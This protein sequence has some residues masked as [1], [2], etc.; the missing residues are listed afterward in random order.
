MLGSSLAHWGVDG[1]LLGE[2]L[3]S[4]TLNLATSA[5]PLIGSYYFLKEQ[6]QINPIQRVFLGLHATTMLRDNNK[7]LDVRQWIFDRLI[8]PLGKLDYLVHTADFTELEQYLLYATRIDNLFNIDMVKENVTYKRGEDYQ[9]NIPPEDED[10]TYYGMGNENTD[11]VYDGSYD[12]EKVGK[13]EYWDRDNVLDISV[14]YLEKIALL[15]QERGIELNIFITP[16]TFEYASIIGDLDDL[17]QY[18]QEFCSAYGANLYDAG[19]IENVYDLFYNE[20]FQDYKH[21][22]RTGSELFLSLI[23]I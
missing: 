15:C 9:N 1:N 12:K 11:E 22:N 18:F 14:E 7:A 10:M 6:S 4:L 13:G 5:Q 17:N 19:Q 21:L 3:D 16:L 20:Y 2:M 8:T 23:H